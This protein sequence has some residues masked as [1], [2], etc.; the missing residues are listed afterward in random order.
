MHDLSEL[1]I[2][3][4]KLKELGFSTPADVAALRFVMDNKDGVG[5]A[6]VAKAAC[7]GKTSTAQRL[8][9][10]LVDQAYVEIRGENYNRRFYATTKAK[11]RFK[12]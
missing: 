2:Q 6:Q 5:L 7:S 4:E 9:S 8:M 1:L 10:R 12:A 3:F 11:R